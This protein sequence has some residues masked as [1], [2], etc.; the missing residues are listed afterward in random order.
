MKFLRTLLGLEPKALGVV[1]GDTVVI[2]R[3]GFSN[4]TLI[5]SA[6]FKVTPIYTKFVKGRGFYKREYIKT[7]HNVL[8][9]VRST[10][11]KR[12]R[13]NWFSELATPDL[14]ITECAIICNK[15]LAAKQIRKQFAI[16]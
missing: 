13:L 11:S 15:R 3:I 4:L 2:D 8:A 7:S 5:K 6:R 9:S 16:N 10:D 14:A 1:I 12:Y